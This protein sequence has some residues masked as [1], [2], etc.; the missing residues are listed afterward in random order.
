MLKNIFDVHSQPIGIMIFHILAFLMALN[1]MT[2][3]L[4]TFVIDS[5]IM[6]A[7]AVIINLTGLM[8]ITQRVYTCRCS[9]PSYNNSVMN[10]QY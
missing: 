8:F 5:N 3:L 6:L 10:T 2:Y 1:T 7:L 4:H 9:L